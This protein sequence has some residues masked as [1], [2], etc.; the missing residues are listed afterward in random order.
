MLTTP[1]K[2]VKM[3]RPIQSIQFAQKPGAGLI[4][5]GNPVI[6]NNPFIVVLITLAG[7]LLAYFVVIF[8]LSG[9]SFDRIRL[10]IRCE[11]RALRDPSFRARVE[12]L[13]EPAQPQAPAK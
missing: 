8:L 4:N 10:A 9:A 3:G 1:G 6:Y 11:W 13:L 7:C 5:R 12:P 2:R